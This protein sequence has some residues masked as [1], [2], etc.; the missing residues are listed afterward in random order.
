MDLA[1][2][3]MQASAALHPHRFPQ[4]KLRWDLLAL[5]SDASKRFV[6]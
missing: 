5:G 2:A 1:G 6:L 4:P 3:E